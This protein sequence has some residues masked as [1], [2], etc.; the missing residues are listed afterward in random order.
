MEL[1]Q[2]PIVTEKMTKKGETLNQYCFIVDREADKLQIKRAVESF[3]KVDVLA[4][5]TIRTP[6]K[7]KVK[8]TKAGIQE[9]KSGMVKKAIVTLKAGQ[10][11]DFYSNI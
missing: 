3:Y 8:Y 5:N 11:I 10:N 6:G 2:K 9:G 4:V 1:L 7:H